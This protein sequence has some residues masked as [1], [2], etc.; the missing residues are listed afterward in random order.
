MK[1]GP[2]R[3]GPFLHIA[4]RRFSQHP[5]M[6]YYARMTVQAHHHQHEQWLL[7]VTAIPTAAGREQRIIAWVKTWVK[8]RRNLALK[9]DKAGNLL[10]TR[11]R[12]GNAKAVPKPL[13][14]TAHLDH[15]AFVVHSIMGDDVLE[16]EFRGGVHDPYFENASIDV[17]DA[18]DHPHRA[19]ITALDSTAKPFKRVKAWLSTP[20][21]AIAAGDIARWAFENEQPLPRIE[22][23]L[24]YTQACDD[25]AAVAAALSA[26]DAIRSRKGF[27]HVGVLL[28]R[29]EEIG[30]I[31][32][33][34]AC[35][36]KSVSKQA[37]LLCLENSRSFAESPIGGGPIVR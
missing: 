4:K 30:F 6:Q 34:A 24:L 12:G 5:V 1:L 25:L 37:R 35:K 29:A 27:E 15:P 10:I 21:N 9:E 36:L 11:K 3:S 23:G 32:A 14:I 19:T 28:T 33:I 20:S 8:A 16:L 13:F 26:L 17:F 18:R 2:C 31:G 7:E 22:N